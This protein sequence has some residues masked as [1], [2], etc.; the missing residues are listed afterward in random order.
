MDTELAIKRT[1]FANDRTFLAAIRTN[2]IFTGISVLLVKNDFYYLPIVILILSILANVI[3]MKTY[4]KHK[5]NNSYR[6]SSLIYSSILLLVLLVLLF[7][8][9]VNN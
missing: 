2:A 5:K 4:L 8:T 3:Q 1:N 9:V 6:D 7:V